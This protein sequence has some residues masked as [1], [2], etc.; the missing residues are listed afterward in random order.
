MMDSKCIVKIGVIGAGGMAA[1]IH[2]PSL[3]R[4]SG[5]KVCAI[6]D[7]EI[8]KAEK[9]AEKFSIAK[10][11]SLYRKM[12]AENELDAVFVLVQ[13]DQTFRITLDCLNAGLDVFTE[14]PAGVTLF[15]AQTLQRKAH[16]KNAVLQV[17]L[18]RRYIPLLSQIVNRMKRETNINQINAYFVK[19]A[20]TT[21]Y[22]NG[23]STF[24][25]CDVIHCIDTLLWI[26]DS[27]PIKAATIEKQYN[28][29]VSS[30]W[31]SVVEFENGITGI[32]Q[33]NY[34]TGGR[35]HGIEIFSETMS[36]YVDLGFGIAGC[37]AELIDHK[38]NMFSMASS[39]SQQASNVEKIDGIA[40]AGDENYYVYYGYLAQDEAFIKS[41]VDRSKP[42][43]GIDES[44]DTIALIDM[45]LA[46]TI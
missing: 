31:N 8:D 30:A 38:T 44:V 42:L 39:G 21:D 41:V 33:S 9:L 12:I 4:I 17:G 16:E 5:A 20:D 15:Q 36:A 14:K 6:C 7:I 28:N 43:S 34:A 32:L 18:N 29:K 13:P 23:C 22:Y 27:K 37:S 46:N 1:D 10:T 11:Y 19:H 45:L 3:A 40:L 26:A 24:F 2:L 35:A 25:F